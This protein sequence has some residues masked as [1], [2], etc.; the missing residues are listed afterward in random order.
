M[1]FTRM[2]PVYEGRMGEVRTLTLDLALD[3][4]SQLDIDATMAT[5]LQAMHE[6]TP[7]ITLATA[8]TDAQREALRTLRTLRERLRASTQC[9]FSQ[10]R[11]VAMQAVRKIAGMAKPR[12]GHRVGAGRPLSTAVLRAGDTYPCEVALGRAGTRSIPVI[13]TSVTVAIDYQESA[14][15]LVTMRFAT[16]LVT[17]DGLRVVAISG[18]PL[19]GGP[20]PSSG[21]AM[22]VTLRRDED[23]HMTLRDAVGHQCG[24]YHM[25]V[26][27]RRHGS[28]RLLLLASTDAQRSLTLS[29]ILPK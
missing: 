21:A 15:R 10:A 16:P 11:S 27:V 19:Q 18:G 6:V 25:G 24:D 22:V 1:R 23:V 17:E 29:L 20:P 8:T 4:A 9:S 3:L 14:G 5:A 2:V 12:G 13:Q 7:P 26:T 28:D